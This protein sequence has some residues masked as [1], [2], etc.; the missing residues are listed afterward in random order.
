[1]HDYLNF[2]QK[3][4]RDKNRT[5]MQWDSSYAG[6]FT[7]KD[8]SETWLPIHPNYVSINVETQKT[9]A[10]STYNYFKSVTSLRKEK[11]FAEGNFNLQVINE[12]VLAYTR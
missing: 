5:P 8:M 4:H 11:A 12:W 7:T 1:M 9:Q 2:V 3:D 10:T 6:G